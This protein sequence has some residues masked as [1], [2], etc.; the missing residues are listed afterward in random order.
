MPVVD[1]DYSAYVY[2]T[3]AI[4][5][6]ALAGSGLWTVLRLSA[7]RRR[8]DAAEKDDPTTTEPSTPGQEH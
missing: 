3:Y 4:A 5:L 2:V 7:A 6:A 1:T 8:L